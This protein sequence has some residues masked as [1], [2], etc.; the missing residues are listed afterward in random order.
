[1]MIGNFCGWVGPHQYNIPKS[2]SWFGPRPTKI[3]IESYGRVI[4]QSENQHGNGIIHRKPVC[5]R[6]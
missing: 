5:M 6:H 1:M 2:N 3:Q 4:N